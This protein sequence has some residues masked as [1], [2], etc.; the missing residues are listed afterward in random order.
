MQRLIVPAEVRPIIGQ[1]VFKISTGE[2]DKHRAVTKAG[3][4]IARLKDRIR[5]A[6]ATVRKPGETEAED[7][8]VAYKARQVADPWSAEPFVLSEVIAFVLKEQGHAWAA[9]GRHVRDAGYDAYAGLQSLPGGD[10]ATR[11]LDAITGQ[12]PPFLKYLN[13]WKHH[14]VLQPRSQ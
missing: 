14:A 3:A 8:A 10:A 9:Y 7:L 6:R 12:A 2:T 13:E 4:I 1:R 11:T 5:P